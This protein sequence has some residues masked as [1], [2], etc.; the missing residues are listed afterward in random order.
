M[1]ADENP[2]LGVVAIGNA[3]VDVLSH[4]DEDFL[5]GHGMVKG[6]MALI[7]TERAEKLYAAMGPGVE[8][9]GGSAANTAV[10][11]AALG[12]SA[13]FIGRVNADQ[14]GEVYAHD[15]RAAGVGF[16]TPPAAD[17]L[18]SGRCLIIVTPDGERTLN[19]YLGASAELGAGDVD[20]A[21]IGAAQIT[22]LEGYLWDA[23]GA[24]EAFVEASRL[25]HAAGRKVALTLSDGFVVDRHRDS[26]RD[27]VADE[28]DILFA[29]EVE[30]CSLYEVDDFDTALTRVLHHCEL[31]AL[32]RSERG[33][34]LITGDTIETVPVHPI[35]GGRLVDATGAGDLYAAGVLYGLTAGYDLARCGR[36]GALAASEVISHLGARPATDLRALAA[37]LLA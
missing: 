19:T 10:G 35:P 6:S 18:P 2:T 36:L 8:V 4:E 1:T 33:S 34:V 12:G 7:D 30:I 5:A 20:P 37:P 16:S 21:L 13:A 25:A 14:L 32:T 24:Q 3:L 9:S 22:F 31:A 27:L 17:G 11:I 15:L 23:P 29:N 28:I 26:F